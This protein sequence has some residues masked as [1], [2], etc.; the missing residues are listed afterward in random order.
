MPQ[1]QSGV[2]WK[3]R[4]EAREYVAV[5]IL[6]ERPLTTSYVREPVLTAH[7]V[8]QRGYRRGGNR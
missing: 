6:Q 8:L 5:W 1:H 2:E 4:V 7:Y 3:V